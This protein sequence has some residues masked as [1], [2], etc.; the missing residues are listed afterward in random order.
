MSK[1][2]LIVIMIFY[3]SLWKLLRHLKLVVYII[4]KSLSTLCEIFL[5][6]FFVAFE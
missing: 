6:I 5:S 3:D 4:T 2:G 1:R